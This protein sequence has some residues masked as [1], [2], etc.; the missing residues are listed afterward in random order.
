[1]IGRA[2]ARDANRANALSKL[3][4]YENGIQARLYKAMR[5]L[6]RRQASRDTGRGTT[7]VIVD[8]DVLGRQAEGA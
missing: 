7:P 3:S 6:E 1:M 8:M 4:R 2:F 5:E